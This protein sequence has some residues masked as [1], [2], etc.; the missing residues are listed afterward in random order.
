MST[1]SKATMDIVLFPTPQEPRENRKEG[2]SSVHN[3]GQVSPNSRLS[4]LNCVSYCRQASNAFKSVPAAAI[5]K[6]DSEV[7]PLQRIVRAASHTSNKA[8]KL[9]Q[10]SASVTEPCKGRRV[11]LGR[12]K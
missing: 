1:Q 10:A 9:T 5:R 6:H 3:L 7:P 4:L 11:L 2:E 12:V 8:E